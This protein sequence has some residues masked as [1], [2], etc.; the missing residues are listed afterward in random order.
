MQIIE[1]I[2]EIRQWRTAT[3]ARAALVPTMGFLHEG[4]L[5]LVREAKAR[6][7]R[8]VVSV[9]VNPAQFGPSEDFARYPR[10]FE[11]DSLLLKKEAVDV[12][13]HPAAEEIY[14]AGFQTQVEVQNLGPL[15]CGISRPDHFRGVATVVLKLFNIV[16]PDL[17]VFG[18][19]DYQQLQ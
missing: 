17:A 5:S 6:A 18:R 1:T 10:D 11:R 19:K 15:L 2:A 9:F 8:V 12:V 7:D 13:F 3:N 14:P 4:H 16:E